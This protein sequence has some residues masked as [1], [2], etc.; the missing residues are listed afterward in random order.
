MVFPSNSRQ[1]ESHRATQGQTGI[2]GV[3]LLHAGDLLGEG[4]ADLVASAIVRNDQHLHQPLLLPHPQM[5]PCSTGP[6]LVAL[7]PLPLSLSLL[8]LH[9]IVCFYLSLP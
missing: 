8:E 7:L 4:S 2:A 6:S 1:I 3:G 5:M 9:G